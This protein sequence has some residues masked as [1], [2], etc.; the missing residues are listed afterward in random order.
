MFPNSKHRSKRTGVFGLYDSLYYAD[1]HVSMAN[2]VAKWEA[3]PNKHLLLLIALFS[4]LEMGLVQRHSTINVLSGNRTRDK[5]SEITH[6]LH[7]AIADP[8]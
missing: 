6:G 1:F 2:V 8:Q 5:H 3:A 4:V 7:S